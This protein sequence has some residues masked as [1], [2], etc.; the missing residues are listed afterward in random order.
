MQIL[1]LARLAFL[2]ERTLPFQLSAAG[3]RRL[4]QPVFVTESLGAPGSGCLTSMKHFKMMR[5]ATW[6]A[7]EGEW[8]MVA[9]MS[10]LNFFFFSQTKVNGG[11]AGASFFYL[12]FWLSLAIALMWKAVVKSAEL[13]KKDVFSYWKISV[14]HPFFW[15]D[16]QR[17]NKWANKKVCRTN[18]PFKLVLI[19]GSLKTITALQITGLSLLISVIIYEERYIFVSGHLRVSKLKSLNNDAILLHLFSIP[20]P[21]PQC[22]Q[23]LPHSTRQWEKKGN[24]IWSN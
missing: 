20:K 11:T 6:K 23:L 14:Q 2:P 5:S 18:L 12:F 9:E 7:R 19:S 1:H 13:K 16:I 3:E 21:F 10:Q 15:N 22:R 17:E 4:S 8:Q 24:S